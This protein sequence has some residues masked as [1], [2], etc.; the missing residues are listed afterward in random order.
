P[1]SCQ[2]AATCTV[3]NSCDVAKSCHVANSCD[4]PKS[5]DIAAACDVEA[6]CQV[7]ASCDVEICKQTTPGGQGTP[8]LA[9]CDIE[10]FACQMS[11]DSDVFRCLQNYSTEMNAADRAVC[12]AQYDARLAALA[13]SG[14]TTFAYSY[15]SAGAV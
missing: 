9:E 7:P 12:E 11:A 15:G 1:K 6:D 3:A 2:V 14:E 5:C 13:K 8:G 10:G 4:V